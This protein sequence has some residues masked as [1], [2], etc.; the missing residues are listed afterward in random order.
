M[1]INLSKLENK[2]NVKVILLP[3]LLTLLESRY[4]AAEKPVFVLPDDVV[5][6]NE[7]YVKKLEADISYIED[8]FKNN[9]TKLEHIKN[10]FAKILKDGDFDAPEDIIGEVCGLINDYIYGSDTEVSAEE[11]E[12]LEGYIE[13][14]GFISVN[15]N[16][17]DDIRLYTKFFDRPI[18]ASGGKTNTIKQIQKKPYVLKYFDGEEINSDVCKLCGSCTY[19]K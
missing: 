15:V 3:E 13:R 9:P 4:F 18:P 8:V 17:G 11:W 2:Y 12:K 10:G 7:D 6:P 14:A 1:N 16:A 5:V 19:F